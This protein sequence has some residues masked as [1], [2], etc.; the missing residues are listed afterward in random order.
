MAVGINTTYQ[1]LSPDTYLVP[2]N[3]T[4]LTLKFHHVPDQHSY[5]RWVSSIEDL[6]SLEDT[7][8]IGHDKDGK[9]DHLTKFTSW[10]FH[11]TGLKRPRAH[12]VYNSSDS[13]ASMYRSKLARADT[14]PRLPELSSPYLPQS[15][16]ENLNHFYTTDECQRLAEEWQLLKNY[17]SIWGTG[18]FQTADIILK[19]GPDIVFIERSTHPGKGSLALPG[20]FIEES[21]KDSLDAGLRE[22]IEETECSLPIETLRLYATRSK[23]FT[24]EGRSE[25][26]IQTTAHL[27]ELPD[28]KYCFVT[29]EYPEGTT[30]LDSVTLSRTSEATTI[31]L[32]HESLLEQYCCRFF[33][34]HKE[35]VQTLLKKQRSTYEQYN[36][37][38]KTTNERLH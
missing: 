9:G 38:N 29:E 7:I 31:S 18:P 28:D 3:N 22:L 36:R 15:V 20:G 24:Q 33:S 14:L 17:H 21:D 4:N 19:C 35:I 16:V 37:A 2:I 11:D 8:I 6:I 5:D 10:E 12:E 30:S 1:K 32:V 25:R 26:N 13:R 34:D 23:H 27:I